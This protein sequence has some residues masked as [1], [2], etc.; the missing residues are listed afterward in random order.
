ML[1]LQFGWLGHTVTIL[2]RHQFQAGSNVEE[3]STTARMEGDDFPSRQEQ[4][5]ALMTKVQ[6]AAWVFAP[7]E[8]YALPVLRLLQHPLPNQAA[9]WVANPHAKVLIPEGS[10]FLLVPDSC[11]RSKTQPSLPRIPPRRPPC[12]GRRRGAIQFFRRPTRKQ[13]SKWGKC[14]SK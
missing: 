14:K 3:R 9:P 13:E 10:P 2:Q 7:L 8:E 11:R 5:E 1:K 4:D 12:Y 6:M